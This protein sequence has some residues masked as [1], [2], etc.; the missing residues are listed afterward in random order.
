MV[1]DSWLPGHAAVSVCTGI[2]KNKTTVCRGHG[3]TPAKCSQQ[4]TTGC[5]QMRGF[6]KFLPTAA[7]GLFCLFA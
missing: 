4:D 3:T 1:G 2:K 6:V 7:K 5:M